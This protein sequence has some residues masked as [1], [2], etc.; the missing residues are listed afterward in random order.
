MKQN[1]SRPWPSPDRPCWGAR[2]CS[3]AAPL[4]SDLNGIRW[5]NIQCLIHWWIVNIFTILSASIA[6]LI[7][8]WEA[9]FEFGWHRRG[10]VE[11][12]P[13]GSHEGAL[14]LRHVVGDVAAVAPVDETLCQIGKLLANTNMFKVVIGCMSVILVHATFD[15]LLCKVFPNGIAVYD[16]NFN[17]S[18]RST[19]IIAGNYAGTGWQW[20]CSD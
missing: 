1:S 2:S 20:M 14:R 8:T 4:I 9:A 17:I 3:S 10:Q 13:G 12:G 6:W 5:F 11:V 19:R 18:C 16:T 7:H 15:R